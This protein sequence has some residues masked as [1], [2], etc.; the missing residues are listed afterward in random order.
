VKPFGSIDRHQ[1]E[2]VIQALTTIGNSGFLSEQPA[3]VTN[4][5]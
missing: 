4:T 1:D 2:S 5:V 3:K